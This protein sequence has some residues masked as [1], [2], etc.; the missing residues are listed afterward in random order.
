MLPPVPLTTPISRRM[1]ALRA[2]LGSLTSVKDPGAADA[3]RTTRDRASAAARTA[4]S[5]RLNILITD[6]S[7]QSARRATTGC[8][9]EALMAGYM[10]KMMPSTTENRKAPM[11][12]VGSGMRIMPSNTSSI[13]LPAIMVPT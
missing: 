8:R 12:M 3:G 4:A 7:F 9:P 13:S 11:A 10:P 2:V 5:S 6:L 1:S